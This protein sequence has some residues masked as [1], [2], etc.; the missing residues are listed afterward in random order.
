MFWKKSQSPKGSLL[1]FQSGPHPLEIFNVILLKHLLFVTLGSWGVNSP[2]NDDNHVKIYIVS[3]LISPSVPPCLCAFLNVSL[4]TFSPSLLSYVQLLLLNLSL[5]QFASFP[6][7]YPSICPSRWNIEWHWQ[8]KSEQ[9]QGIRTSLHYDATLHILELNMKHWSV[10][11]CGW[12]KY[13]FF[14]FSLQCIG[15][16]LCQKKWKWYGVW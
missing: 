10:R 6:C 16:L 2:L 9:Y 15:T 11:L 14:M 5:C 8:S 7:I 1:Q 3:D 13:H 12:Y 4:F